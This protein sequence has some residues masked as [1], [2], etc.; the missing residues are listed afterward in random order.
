MIKKIGNPGVITNLVE[1][2]GATVGTLWTHGDT[3]ILV[4]LTGQRMYISN[5]NVY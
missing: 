4:L 3:E 2:P 1:R 5:K